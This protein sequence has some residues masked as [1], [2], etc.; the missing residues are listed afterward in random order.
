MGYL[1]E[2]W[3]YEKVITC[4]FG[5]LLKVT[6]LFTLTVCFTCTGNKTHNVILRPKFEK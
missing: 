5:F 6:V 2:T 3:V 1:R 4:R